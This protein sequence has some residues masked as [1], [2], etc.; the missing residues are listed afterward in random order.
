MKQI[1]YL[2]VYEHDGSYAGGLLV[3]NQRGL[4]IDFRYVEPIKPTKLQELIYGA[5]LRR[6][7]KVEAIGV[8]LLQSCA[9]NYT[10]TF[11]DDEIFFELSDRCK[12]PIVKVEKSKNDP[13]AEAGKWE[14][15]N[16]E[17]VVFQAKEGDNPIS[18]HF[19]DVD[20]GS[21]EKFM[22]DFSSLAETLDILEPLERV[23]RAIVEIGK[24][25]GEVK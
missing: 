7:I 10:A 23:K 24:S 16:G 25:N 17:G 21:I 14:N 22:Q 5:A 4:P 6:Y 1:A 9:A 11:V 2:G 3:C 20:N 8:G 13:L 12:S 18:L 15:L 19:A